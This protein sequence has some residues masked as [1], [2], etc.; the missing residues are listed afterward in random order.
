MARRDAGRFTGDLAV[1]H[2]VFNRFK[3]ATTFALRLWPS[4]A[5]GLSLAGSYGEGIAQPTFFDLY[6]FFPGSFVGNPS[7]K[8]E[9][10]RGFEVS[11][12]YRA[13]T[14]RRIADRSIASA[15][16]TRSST[17]VDFT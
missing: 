2:D 13:R 3:D 11:L 4:S 1:R 16:T 7:L 8:P 17:T 14:V 12:R 10:S 15:C 9:S 5:A 6:G